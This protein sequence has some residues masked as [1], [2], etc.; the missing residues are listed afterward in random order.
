VYAA[1]K[2]LGEMGDKLPAPDKASLQDAIDKLKTAIT[3]NDAAQMTAAME[4]LTQ[5]QHKAAEALY[6]NAGTTAGAPPG[7]EAGPSAE[8]GGAGAGAPKDGE[9]IDAEVVEEEK[10]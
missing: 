8:A 10:K 6:K 1:E 2:T 7:A 5:A 3:A 9:V 4:A